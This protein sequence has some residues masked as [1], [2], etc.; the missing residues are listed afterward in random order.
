MLSD[1][2]RFG[3]PGSPCRAPARFLDHPENTANLVSVV[4]QDPAI[5]YALRESNVVGC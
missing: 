4:P 3:R 5:C 1:S 2:R